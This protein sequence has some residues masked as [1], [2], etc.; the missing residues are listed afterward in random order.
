MLIFLQLLLNISKMKFHKSEYD[1]FARVIEQAGFEPTAFSFVKK[2]GNVKI[3]HPDIAGIFVFHRKS[4]S[5]RLTEKKKRLTHQYEAGIVP[6][7]IPMSSF[8]EVL[9]IF[10][11]WIEQ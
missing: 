9:L 8:E 3:S 6:H 4:E 7:L 1:Q 10:T 2:K 11:K 5:L